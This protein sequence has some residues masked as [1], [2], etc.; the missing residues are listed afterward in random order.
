MFF[1]LRNNSNCKSTLPHIHTQMRFYWIMQPKSPYFIGGGSGKFIPSF[2][3]GSVSFVLKG[4]GGSCVFY[5]P[6]FQMLRPITPPPLYFLASHLHRRVLSRN[7]MQFLSRG[8]YVA[9]SKSRVLTSCDFS[10]IYRRG[11]RR[12]SRNTKTLSSSFTFAQEHSFCLRNRRALTFC[13][14]KLH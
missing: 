2:R 13:T 5:P 7:S 11:V 6:H 10:A 4:R 9:T 1:L 8:S 3:G 14:D 12:N